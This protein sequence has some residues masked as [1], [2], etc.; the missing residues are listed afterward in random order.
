MVNMAL[1]LPHAPTADEMI[2]DSLGTCKLNIH[3]AVE[4]TSQLTNSS[5]IMES[6]SAAPCFGQQTT[7]YWCLLLLAQVLTALI[8]IVSMDEAFVELWLLEVLEG[9]NNDGQWKVIVKMLSKTSNITLS[10]WTI[11]SDTASNVD[12]QNV[13]PKVC[14]QWHP[15]HTRNHKIR[16]FIH[17]CIR[18]LL[19]EAPFY[20]V[21]QWVRIRWK[22]ATLRLISALCRYI[23]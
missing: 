13:W 17:S 11:F 1:G 9:G 20:H 10:V 15:I 18:R 16:Y 2:I 19:K 14:P 23:Q 21:Y 5:Q 22:T 8:R 7:V 4:W 12:V 3:C 6:L